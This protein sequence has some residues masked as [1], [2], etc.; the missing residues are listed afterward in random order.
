MHQ[1][2]FEI[3]QTIVNAHYSIP[4]A[5]TPDLFF[6]VNS[7]YRCLSLLLDA[8]KVARIMRQNAKSVNF[9]KSVIIHTSIAYMPIKN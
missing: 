7:E 6:C 1:T 5:F 2:L 3:V 8:N 9:S 4:I